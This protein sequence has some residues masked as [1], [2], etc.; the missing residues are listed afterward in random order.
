M[1]MERGFRGF[2]FFAALGL[3][4]QLACSSGPY[5]MSATGDQKP[6]WLRA[7]PYK[8]GGKRFYVG[9]SSDAETSEDGYRLATSDALRS[10]L[11]EVGVTVG[12]ESTAFQQEHDGQFSYDV[13]LKVTTRADPVKVRKMAV[14]HRYQETWSRNGTA[15][16]TWV[17][18]SLPEAEIA[19][20]L[21]DAAGKVLLVWNC[22][23]DP[24]KACRN[25]LRD[26]V[27]Q[28]VTEAGRPLLPETA[29]AEG[30]NLAEL[31]AQKGAAFIL[32]V[33]VVGEFLSAR[34]GEFYAHGTA[35]AQFIQTD[36]GKVLHSLEI[37][38]E[39]GG[40]FSKAEAVKVALDEV[41]KELGTQL[42]YKL[43]H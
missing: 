33:K 15:F 24:D 12:E 42:R 39:K 6:A 43:T 16:D 11:Q 9:R 19:R 30:G 3:A 41:V 23:A 18:I 10:F 29:A 25:A 37:G 38:P 35:T 4:I 7:T 21:R 26:N 22:R 28:A 32:E 14:A 2:P 8:K 20:A 13:Q 5:M 40:H 31:G 17:V 34:H 1:L 36:G 27:R